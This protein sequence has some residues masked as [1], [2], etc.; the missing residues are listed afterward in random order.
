MSLSKIMSIVPKLDAAISGFMH[1]EDRTA[2]IIDLMA[3]MKSNTKVAMILFPTSTKQVLIQAQ[4]I[5][6][7]LRGF[8]INMDDTITDEEEGS[9]TVVREL[10]QSNQAAADTEQ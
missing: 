2:E 7:R 5:V 9:V 10:S 1:G 8:N 4:S 6:N 3:E